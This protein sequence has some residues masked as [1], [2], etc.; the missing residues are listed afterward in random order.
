[1]Q[2]RIPDDLAHEAFRVLARPDHES[3]TPYVKTLLRREIANQ[4]AGGVQAAIGAGRRDE[5]T[6]AGVVQELLCEAADAVEVF[7]GETPLSQ[8]LRSTA[9]QAAWETAS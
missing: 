9:A 7:A 3:L 5:Q 1:M 4:K 2:I 8:K 6:S